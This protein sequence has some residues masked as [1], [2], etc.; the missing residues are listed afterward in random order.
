MIRPQQR[1]AKEHREMVANLR[2]G[3]NVTLSGGIKG[4]V[5]KVEEQ[6][7]TVEIAQD[8]RVKVIKSTIAEVNAKGE[9][10]AP[11]PERRQEKRRQEQVGLIGPGH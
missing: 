2:R 8:V 10:A 6:D 7:A 3:D 4:K 5:T 11:A 9:P 1:R